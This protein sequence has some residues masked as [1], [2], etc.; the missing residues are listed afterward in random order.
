MPHIDVP[1]W[2][3]VAFNGYVIALLLLDL[4]GFNR[5]AH[6]IEWKE[7]A[8]LSAFFVAASLAVNALIWWAYGSGPGL[9][10]LTAYVV[11]KSLS[12]DNLFVIAVLF[13]YF[14]VPAQYQ[15]RV[16]FWGIFGAIV[17]R[18]VMILVGVALVERFH[19]VLYIFGAF[20][21]LTGIRM[22]VESEEPEEVSSN[23]VLQLLRRLLPVTRGYHG[24]HF[25]VRKLGRLW[26]T[27]LFL[28]LVMIELTDVVFA[29]D[30]IPAIL[31]ITTDPFIAYSSNILAVVGLR[32][33]YF[34]LA[35][36][37]ER[38][39]YLH[40]GLAAVLVFI[41]AKMLAEP[42]LEPRGL[43]I[44]TSVSLAVV[45]GCITV[46]A[47]V[48]WAAT[49]RERR[50]DT[51]PEPPGAPKPHAGDGAAESPPLVDDR[52]RSEA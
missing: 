46:A 14:A 40:I 10:F 36:V 38:I 19:W 7:A 5:K 50:S 34:L 4:F 32:A 41:G 43:E 35:G 15:H 37:I 44:P 39:R 48:S 49:V 27:P 29:V 17:M 25:F 30:S 28:V 26:V 47:A 20:L 42:F 33:L 1:A 18:A 12:V 51:L 31:G 9:T 21:V 2:A 45:I 24:E 11:E 8:W 13:G 6:K 52:E 22:F 3:W 23:K 16:L